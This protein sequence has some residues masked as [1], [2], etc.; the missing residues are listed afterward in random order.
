MI[1]SILT[2]LTLAGILTGLGLALRARRRPASIGGTRVDWH[3]PDSPE[4]EEEGPDELDV[5]DEEEVR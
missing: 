3:G 4:D 1:T 5:L 2:F